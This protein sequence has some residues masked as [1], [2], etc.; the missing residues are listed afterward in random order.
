MA[1]LK[2]RLRA[3]G[4]HLALSMVVA[5]LAATLVF[6]LWYPY[7]YRALSGGRELF[8]LLMGVDVV[9][10]PVITFFIYNPIKKLR[11]ELLLDLALVGLLQMAALGYGLWTVS[12]ARPVHL[13]FEYSRFSVAHANQVPD[14]LLD[15]VPQG[16]VPLP[17][18]GPTLLSLRPF[19]N[20]QERM[21][22]TVAA[23][24]GAPLPGRVDLWQPYP[25]AR[26][27]VLQ[28]ARPLSELRTRFPEMGGQMDELLRTVG[29]TWERSAY[30][31]LVGRKM[32]WT[33]V[34]DNQSADVIGFLPVDPF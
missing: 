1:S 29:Q 18:T 27:A 17:W 28:Q 19:K 10:G 5:A 2:I 30:L 34:I 14:A 26:D 6:G 7:P 13:V 23:M 11:R 15:R 22:A 25:M 33:V 9:I 3:F 8:L 16:I 32:A 12:Q 4:M 20:T 24:S 31:P 21:D